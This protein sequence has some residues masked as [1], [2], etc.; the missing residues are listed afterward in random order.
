MFYQI[1]HDMAET[2]PRADLMPA[3]PD[4]LLRIAWTIIVL[5]AGYYGVCAYFAQQRKQK[6]T[7]NMLLPRWKNKL[8][9]L[10]GSVI[11]LTA[12]NVLFSTIYAGQYFWHKLEL[13]FLAMLVIC[14]AATDRRFHLIPNSFIIIGLGVKAAG[15]LYEGFAIGWDHALRT[16]LNGLLGAI[17]VCVFFVIIAL[18]FKNSIG[19]GDIK[20]FALICLFQGLAAGVTSIFLS[21]L[22]AFAISVGLLIIKRK[23]RKDSIPLAP[24]IMMGTIACIILTGM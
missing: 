8:L 19:M 23:S 1:A 9:F 4:L 15:Y 14:T 12:L 16:C 24:S 7:R 5:A 20:L 22:A 6:L 13:L 21:L 2:Q 10:L 3:L 17:I 11:V 18:V